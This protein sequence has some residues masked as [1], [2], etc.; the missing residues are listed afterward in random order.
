MQPIMAS[1][2]R[3]PS[4]FL[5]CRTALTQGWSSPDHSPPLPRF[6]YYD[7]RDVLGWR[8]FPVVVFLEFACHI[9]FSWDGVGSRHSNLLKCVHCFFPITIT[10]TGKNVFFFKKW[11]VFQNLLKTHSWSQVAQY[12]SDSYAHTLTNQPSGRN[13][14]TC[15][16]IRFWLSL[17]LPWFSYHD[18]RD[19]LGWRG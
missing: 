19:V 16:K 11:K 2:R 7:S 1:G 5:D 18:S 15:L 4:A 3:S 12:I 9:I 6:S 14:L 8:G 13:Y 17:P 10:Q